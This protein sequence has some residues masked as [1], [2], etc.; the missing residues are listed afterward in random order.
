MGGSVCHLVRDK[1]LW[2]GKPVG[3]LKWTIV[4][5]S[6]IA[7]LAHWSANG[8]REEYF[9]RK[10][11][12]EHPNDAN[13]WLELAQH[14]SNEGDT[15]AADSGDEDHS[16]PDPTPSYSEALDCLNQDVSLGRGGYK[17]P[18]ARAEPAD[19]PGDQQKAVS[20]GREALNLAP[21]SPAPA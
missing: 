3:I 10:N 13:A 21:P 16:A 12:K 18:P 14:Y 4:L 2:R 11:V 1:V 8:Q 17:V 6:G 7:L 9:L 19:K 20:F 15:L 5:A